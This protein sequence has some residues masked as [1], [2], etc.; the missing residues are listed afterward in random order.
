VELLHERLTPLRDRTEKDVR[1]MVFRENTEGLYVGVGGFFKKGTADEIAVQEDVNSRKGVERII[2][3]A[4]AY[5]RENGL[6]R[7]CMSDK[8][9]A[10]TFAHDLWQRV[11][12][13]MRQEYA[14]I[15]SRHLYI[16]TL[17]MEIVRDPR[18][19]DVIVTCNLFGD[20]ISDLGAQLAGGLGLAP[21]GNIHPGRTSLFEPVHGS[22]PTIA[23]KGIANPLGSVLTAGMLLDF[24]GWKAEALAVHS[25]VREALLKNY[26]TP[27]LG[28]TKKTVEVGDWLAE[29]V[30]QSAA[31]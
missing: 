29:Y 30:S 22:A 14:G 27:D 6:K 25:A 21:S 8:S 26:L 24:L 16:D 2:R 11:F 5:A 31:T 7:V 15:D 10:M 1:I 19:F 28:G 9:N 4:F 23:G 17:A 3:Y 20:I 12:K 18:Q 13:E